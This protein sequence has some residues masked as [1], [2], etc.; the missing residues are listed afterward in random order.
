[1]NYIKSHARYLL[2]NGLLFEINRRVLHPLGLAL[3]AEIDKS[4]KKQ[5]VLSG[6]IETQDEEGYFFDSDSFEVGNEKFV[7]FMTKIG[8]KRIENRKKKAGFIEQET[9]NV[10][11]VTDF[12]KK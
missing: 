8:N 12:V 3:V 11:L 10:S 2:D 4:N 5:I 1:M 9:P 7:S 6:I